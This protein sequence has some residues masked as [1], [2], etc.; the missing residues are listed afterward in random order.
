MLALYARPKHPGTY[1]YALFIA[2]RSGLGPTTKH[3]VKNTLQVDIAG[4]AAQPWRY[5]QTNI[6]DVTNEQRLLAQIVIAK[7]TSSL[8][9]AQEIL[10]TVPV[11][12]V[13]DVDS[14]DGANP[15]SCRTWVRDAFG[16]LRKQGALKPQTEDWEDVERKALEYLDK[17]RGQGRW[18]S[19]WKGGKGVPLIDLLEGIE[20][21]K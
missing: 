21:V 11:Y 10:Q 20:L 18:E 1:H 13:D 7:V 4:Q 19:T 9:R 6:Q 2:P 3:H 14:P 5:E 16:E 12:Q 17:K 15:F 8:N